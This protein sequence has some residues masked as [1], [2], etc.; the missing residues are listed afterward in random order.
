MTSGRCGRW[1]AYFTAALLLAGGSLAP[2]QAQTKSEQQK[3]PTKQITFLFGNQ[4]GG[5]V[6]LLA[7]IYGELIQRST[8]QTVVLEVKA[9][10]GG[11]IAAQAL[12]NARPDG[13]TIML[14]LGGMH[15]VTPHLQ[16]VPF[17]P[18]NDFQPVTML[19]S[20]PVILTVRSDSPVKSIAEL[21]ASSKAKPKGLTY[22]TPG[23]GSPMHLMGALF[24]N[25]SGA[26]VEHIGYRGGPPMLAALLSGEVDYGWV[27]YS[28]I[29]GNPEKMRPLA[30]ANKQRSNV[31][32]DVPTFTEL[33]FKGIDLDN[34]FGI[35]T[36]KGT[37]PWIVARLRD[38]FM[39]A[40]GT[41]EVRKRIAD[42]GYNWLATTPEEFRAVMQRDYDTLGKV[43][44]EQ[45]IK[46]EG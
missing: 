16:P 46:R 1:T 23:P 25:A 2:A 42:E 41:P 40:H 8:G 12:N 35:I 10:A 27:A 15:T 34:W 38:E 30:V 11:V 44:K 7:R 18:I 5:V 6:D 17:D 28:Q 22:G 13:H 43:I 9:G 26:N 29:R 32:P 3:W 37:P 20:F 4:P 39:R 14:A 24:Q 19:F 36:T 33:G 21:V 45:N 31:L